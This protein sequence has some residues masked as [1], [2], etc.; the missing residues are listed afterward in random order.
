MSDRTPIAIHWRLSEE[1]EKKQKYG[2]TNLDFSKQLKLR[3]NVI[4]WAHWDW[5]ITVI[6]VQHF[7]HFLH[8]WVDLWFGIFKFIAKVIKH[9]E[10]SI[11][12]TN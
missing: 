1:R 9:A 7:C 6:H 8:G 12:D 11:D 2:E 4:N 5:T 3:A 10:I